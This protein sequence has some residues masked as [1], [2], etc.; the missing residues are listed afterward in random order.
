MFKRVREDNIILF[1]TL[2]LVVAGLVMVYSASSVMALRKKADSF[3]FLKRQAVWV[4]IGLA[5][6]FAAW[7]TDY[8]KL[9]RP[10]LPLLAVVALLLVGVML[11]GIGAEINGAKRWIR[12]AGLTFQPSEFLKPVLLVTI[13]ASLAKRS[14]R[15]GEFWTGVGP[16]LAMTGMFALLIMLEPDLGTAATIFAVVLSMI[17][18]SGMRLTHLGYMSLAVLPVLYYELFRVGFRLQRL[19]VFLDPWQDPLGKGFQTIQ[20]FLAFGGGGLTG[21]GLGAGRQKLMFLPEPHS[22]FIFSVIGE[23]LG[24]MGSMTVAVMFM[25][26]TLCGIRLSLRCEDPFGRVLAFGLTMMIGLQSII[27]MG[28]ATGLFPNKGMP[29]PFMSAGGSS[30]MVALLSVGILLSIAKSGRDED[31]PRASAQAR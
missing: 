19:M 28:V 5:A 18:V 3:Y 2:F 10:A 13:S 26:F 6:M 7:N 15:L 8:K 31:S 20:S 29:L 9:K 14:D 12:L 23:E 1:I 4:G 24:L 17:F 30:V 25:V 27:N 21:L 16:Y 22:D 11:P